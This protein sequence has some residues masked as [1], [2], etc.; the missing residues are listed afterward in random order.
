MT[1]KDWLKDLANRNT[2]NQTDEIMMSSLL[3][4]LKYDKAYVVAGVA[5][6]NGYVEPV[7][8]HQLAKTLVKIIDMPK[9]TLTGE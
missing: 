4:Q 8:I 1:V 5:Y 2:S 3:H 6:L 9:I 7:S